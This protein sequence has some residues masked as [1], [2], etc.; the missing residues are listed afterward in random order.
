[1][2]IHFGRSRKW[3]LLSLNKILYFPRI[4]KTRE[5]RFLAL[6]IF[7]ILSSGTLLAVRTYARLTIPVPASGGSY[8]EG[9]L[10][11]PQSINPL[12]IPANDTDRDISRLVFSGLFTYNGN[13]ELIPDLAERYEVSGDE[14]TYTIHLRDN[15][16]WQDGKPLTVEDVLFTIGRIQNPLYKSQLRQ[17]WQGVTAEKA[18]D[19]TIRLTLRTPYVP[20][21]EN[22]TLRI[23]PK[24]LWEQIG[25]DQSLLHE[26][27]LKPV[28]SGPYKF[29]T[30]KTDAK[31]LIVWYRLKRNDRYYRGVPYIT[32]ITFRFYD[33][34]EAVIAAWRK[35]EINAFGPIPNSFSSSLDPM[36]GT[37]EAIHI[38]RIFGIFIN[39][40]NT[41]ILQDAHVRQAIAYAINRQDITQ[42]AI[43]GGAIPYSAALPSFSLNKSASSTVT[44]HDPEHARQ[45]LTDAGWIDTDGDGIREKDIQKRASSTPITQKGKTSAKPQTEHTQ[46]QFTLTTSDWPDL[47]HAAE[48]IKEELAGIGIGVT[49]DSKAFPDLETSVIKPRVF[50]LL[51]FGQAYGYEP[52]PFAFWHS[53]QEKD[54]GLNITQ[55]KNPTVDTLLE[56][57]RKEPNTNTRK[58]L[59]T[60]AEALVEKD[61]P[62]V[63]LFSQL[64]QYLLPPEIK[65]VHIDRI[66]LPADRFNEVEKWYLTTGRT[67][68]G[69]K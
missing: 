27:N 45:L 47:V 60:K 65:G 9:L 57:A 22:L 68:R 25:P 63:F 35:G 62:A 24:H 23:I 7:I 12:Y 13:G 49:I 58:D 21:V 4:L 37:I 55:Y 6:L 46:L 56:D 14:K 48:L 15:L 34:E 66:S 61:V 51:L 11:V 17:N 52:D 31:G 44:D 36:K 39:D 28:G 29:D 2:D 32:D 64:Y 10:K 19:H 26:L 69:F 16:T 53:S 30:F 67:F 50:S 33:T 20:F 1:M 8:Q 59:Y 40:T 54:P 43:F 42:K 5:K 38:P 18:D 41:P 3:R